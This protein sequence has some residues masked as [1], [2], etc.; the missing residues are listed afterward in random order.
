MS[1]GLM[2]AQAILGGKLFPEL[3]AA[4]VLAVLHFATTESA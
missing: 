3:P 1:E 4:E 2:R